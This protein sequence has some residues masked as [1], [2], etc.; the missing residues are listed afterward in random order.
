MD[1]SHVEEGGSLGTH[2]PLGLAVLLQTASATCTSCC[3]ADQPLLP[4]LHSNS[5]VPSSAARCT[6]QFAR[7]TVCLLSCCVPRDLEGRLAAA[8]RPPRGPIQHGSLGQRS[9]PCVG[10][11]GTKDRVTGGTLQLPEYRDW[12]PACTACGW[13]PAYPD[14]AATLTQQ[15]THQCSGAQ[16]LVRCGCVHRQPTWCGAP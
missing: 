1:Y 6:V 13:P 3:V 12:G 15:R 5:C 7:R 16:V 9:S 8:C 10:R 2:A 4:C 11:A 14:A